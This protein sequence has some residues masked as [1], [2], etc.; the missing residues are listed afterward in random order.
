L[1]E[2]VCTV[3]AAFGRRF[4]ILLDCHDNSSKFSEF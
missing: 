1:Q 3:H 4:L 2:V